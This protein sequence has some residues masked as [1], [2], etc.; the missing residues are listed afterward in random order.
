[1]YRLFSAFTFIILAF[2]SAACGSQGVSATAIKVAVQQS[3]SSVPSE[4]S[5]IKTVNVY[6]EKTEQSAAEAAAP[7]Q[8]DLSATSKKT[9]TSKSTVDQNELA[10]NLYNGYAWI[11]KDGIDSCYNEKGELLFTLPKGTRAA[12]VFYDGYAAVMQKDKSG[13]AYVSAIIDTKGNTVF[14]TKKIGADGFIFGIYENQPIS[15]FK[16]TKYREDSENTFGDFN[17]LLPVEDRFLED[18]YIF[19]YTL[20][21]SY[22]GTDF[23]VGVVNMKG[24][25]EVPM[26]KDNIASVG[27][28]YSP[29]ELLQNLSYCG[30]GNFMKVKS[31]Y[32][33]DDISTIFNVDFYNFDANSW[34]S[35]VGD[36]LK[37]YHDTFGLTFEDGVAI[38]VGSVTDG[39]TYIYAPVSGDK[40]VK[41]DNRELKY[42]SDNGYTYFYNYDRTGRVIFAY[43]GK[44]GTNV[45]GLDEELN[46]IFRTDLKYCFPAHDS[47]NGYIPVNI[48]NDKGTEYWSVLDSKGEF[49]FEPR[50]GAISRC[51]EFIIDEK[52]IFFKCSNNYGEEYGTVYDLKGNE[53]KDFEDYKYTYLSYRNGVVKTVTK[54]GA[55]TEYV[56]L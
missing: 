51:D 45:I 41:I 21:E 39:M 55:K 27:K 15:G 22:A 9:T 29:G 16:S 53:V 34:Q 54:D 48:R 30:E 7:A 31:S 35:L 43:G 18:G 26:A 1:M 37:Y 24:E 19:A 32:G 2:G 14:D 56:R 28:D 47:C 38:G 40:Q 46:E 8:E 50:E 36:N 25:W 4:S 20:S 23:Q 11:T 5:Q 49:V 17:D 12:S 44:E 52:Y 3:A 6:S 13:N 10:Y 42:S 33:L